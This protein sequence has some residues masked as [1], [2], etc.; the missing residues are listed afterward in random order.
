LALTPREKE[1]WALT[2][3]QQKEKLAEL[4]VL[5]KDMPGNTADRIA[6]I[7]KLEGPGGAG[8]KPA[9][10]AAV[11]APPAAGYTIYRPD[12][13]HT[14]TQDPDITKWTDHGYE[15]TVD[16]NGKIIDIYNPA[17]KNVF[18]ATGKIIGTRDDFY[19]TG[20]IKPIPAAP[21]PTTP[22]VTSTPTAPVTPTAPAVP[23]GETT[24]YTADDY[25][26]F[27]PT[28]IIGIFLHH[29]LQVTVDD[30]A[31]IIDL[32]DPSTGNYFDADGN[33]LGT[34]TKPYGQT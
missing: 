32:W 28:S 31:N 11:T 8:V 14:T 20:E 9:A 29:G 23:I 4:G 3:A 5:P 2:P 13:Y 10:P 19:G 18:D 21:A 17:T 16:E 24:T 1:L 33:K 22:P 15:V 26:S 30:H 27:G 6:L 25:A 7:I 12:P 34:R